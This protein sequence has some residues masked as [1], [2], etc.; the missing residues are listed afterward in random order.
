MAAP[1][2]SQA[3]PQGARPRSTHVKVRWSAPASCD[4]SALTD[5]IDRMLAAS[6]LDEPV[7]I[8]AAV[9]REGVKWRVVAHFDAGPK[10]HGVRRFEGQSCT[11]V[12]S[13]AALAVALAVDPC[14][15]DRLA[16]DGTSDPPPLVPD[17]NAVAEAGSDTP[18]RVAPTMVVEEQVVP[19]PLAPVREDDEGDDDL[20]GIGPIEAASRPTAEPATPWRA[21]AALGGFVDGFALPQ[22][23]L[24]AAA[25]LGVTR[26]RFRAELL[27]TY[28]LPSTRSSEAVEGAGG[29]FS[30]WTVEPGACFVPRA[31]PLELPL[32]TSVQAG[33]TMGRGYGVAETSVARQPWVAVAGGLGLAWPVSPRF[34]LFGRA[35][36]AIPVLRPDY[37]I[38]GA[39]TVHRTGPV[40]L[41]GQLGIEVRLP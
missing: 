27:G 6:T 34:A 9:T 30:Q 35:T 4:V 31:G 21:V 19:T 24:G 7:V 41:R 38:V 29:R 18:P 26:G 12:A 33:Q 13:A 28:R 40:V 2:V 16:E 32:C 11:T 8:D 17:P 3:G 36:L 15:L 1:A 14:V 23:G 5:P 10:R 39:G 37:A 25:M 20:A 22:V